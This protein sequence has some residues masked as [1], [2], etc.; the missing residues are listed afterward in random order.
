MRELAKRWLENFMT[1]STDLRYKNRKKKS[2]KG[3]QKK[4]LTH[5]HNTHVCVHEC[6]CVCVCE[7]GRINSNVCTY[8][9]IKILVFTV[10]RAI[11]TNI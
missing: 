4:L 10:N 3:E 1:I 6:V 2:F 7:N 5:T 8:V 9:C 11:H